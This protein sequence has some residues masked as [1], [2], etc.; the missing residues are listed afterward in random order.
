MRKIILRIIVITALL[1]VV[2]N[3]LMSAAVVRKMNEREL[4]YDADDYFLLVDQEHQCMGF[5][6]GSIPLKHVGYKG[7]VP[8]GVYEA[9][10][11]WNEG[12][13]LE[14]GNLH[15]MIRLPASMMRW[16][17]KNYKS[18]QPALVYGGQANEK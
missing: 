12:I 5:Y 17:E 9:E 8:D 4:H 14:D 11:I 15:V 13:L 3:L 16:I 1:L 2:I 18:G 10:I 7:Q 6:Y